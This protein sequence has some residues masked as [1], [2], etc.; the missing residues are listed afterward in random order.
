MCLMVAGMSL[1]TDL[2]DPLNAEMERKFR[3]K[4]VSSWEYFRDL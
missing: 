3:E 1:S 2:W 4:E